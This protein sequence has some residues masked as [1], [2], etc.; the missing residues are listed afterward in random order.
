VTK[1]NHITP[2]S[3]ILLAALPASVVFSGP[4]VCLGAIVWLTAK[5]IVVGVGLGE[6]STAVVFGNGSIVVTC[7]SAKSNGVIVK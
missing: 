2:V 6:T 7:L 1:I 3:W 4:L 5:S